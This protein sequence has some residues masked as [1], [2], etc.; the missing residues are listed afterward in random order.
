MTSNRFR[1]GRRIINSHV[2]FHG[3][4]LCNTYDCDCNEKKCVCTHFQRECDV[5]K[6]EPILVIAKRR[7][8][9]LD[10]KE[11]GVETKCKEIVGALAEGGDETSE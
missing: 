11:I 8:I 3:I 6:E 5:A 2:K 10:R 1:R 4:L 9:G 7:Q